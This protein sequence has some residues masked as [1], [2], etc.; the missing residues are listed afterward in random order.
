MIAKKVMITFDD[1]Y[2]VCTFITMSLI[3]WEDG[4][5]INEAV[6]AIFDVVNRH[7]R[8]MED[9]QPPFELII[10]LQ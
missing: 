8:I 4:D 7:Y 2:Y 10:L 3:D 6:Y 1:S 9:P 5:K